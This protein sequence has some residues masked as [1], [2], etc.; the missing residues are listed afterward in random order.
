MHGNYTVEAAQKPSIVSVV[1]PNGIIS[2]FFWRGGNLQLKVIQGVGLYITVIYSNS[3]LVLWLITG[4]PFLIKKS[5]NATLIIH[6]IT[7]AQILIMLFPSTPNLILSLLPQW[8]PYVGMKAVTPCYSE[9]ECV[10]L[11][12]KHGL[13]M[14]KSCWAH[15]RGHAGCSLWYVFAA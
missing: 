13:S 10:S 2:E 14:F 1:R 3:H 15:H 9:L 12:L 6:Q 4:L 5:V 11:R 8:L 7:V